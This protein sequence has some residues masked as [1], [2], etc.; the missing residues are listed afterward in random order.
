MGNIEQR[1]ATGIT[2]GIHYL[3]ASVIQIRLETS[4]LIENIKSYLSGYV[5]VYI[6]G[7]DGDVKMKQDKIA[8]PKA[9]NEGVHSVLSFVTAVINA[10]VVQGNFT[11]DQYNTYIA[12]FNTDL[13]RNIMNNLYLWNIDEDEV[14]PIINHIMSLVQPFISRL[15]DNKER[16]SYAQSLKVVES[17]TLQEKRRLPKSVV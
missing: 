6:R 15:I 4:E 1:Q 13:L 5:T 3:D 10:Q 16:E 17:N 8:K 14:L 9:N 7:D 11:E 12:E 2:Q